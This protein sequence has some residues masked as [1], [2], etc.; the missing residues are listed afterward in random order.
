[1]SIIV[2]NIPPEL[3]ELPQWLL[4]RRELRGDKPTKIPY[5]PC[6][7]KNA[8]SNDPATWCNFEEAIAVADK[9]DGIGFV[10]SPNDPFIGIDLDH[11]VDPTTG[12]ILPWSPEQIAACKHW[13]PTIPDP[14]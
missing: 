12:Q 11:C 5:Q 8:K 2:E 3:R 10:F 13:S 1:M 4:W 7:I 14:E 9:F 6:G